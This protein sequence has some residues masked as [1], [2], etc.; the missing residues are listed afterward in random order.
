[1]TG[2][3]ALLGQTV[4]HDGHIFEEKYL[5]AGQGKAAADEF[6]KVINH[7]GIVWNCWTGAM[8]KLGVARANASQAKTQQGADAARTHALAAYKGSFTFWKDADPDVPIL[9]QSM[10]EYAKL[11]QRT[12][13]SRATL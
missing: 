9:K 3:T 10:S 11:Q 5:A 7:S 4:S 13:L 1:M 8:A 2:P 6:Q 12:P